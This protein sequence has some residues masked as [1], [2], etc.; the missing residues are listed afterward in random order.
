MK[1]TKTKVVKMNLS[2]PSDFF[3]VI[4]ENARSNYMKAA[5]WT[6]QFLMKNLLTNN[7]RKNSSNENE[8]N[9]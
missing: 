9:M 7:E 2:L 8:R 3:E 5:T 4:Q 1:K 6:K